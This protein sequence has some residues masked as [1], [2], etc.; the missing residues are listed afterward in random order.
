MYMC[1]LGSIEINLNKMP[2]PAKTAKKCK[3]TQ[4]TDFNPQ[5]T[6]VSLFDQKKL[7]GFWP[8]YAINEG[9]PQVTV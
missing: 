9:S 7:N 5:A 2:R 4:L 6:C 8:V 1:T 3:L